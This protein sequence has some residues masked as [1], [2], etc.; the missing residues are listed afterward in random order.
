VYWGDDPYSPSAQRYDVDVVRPRVFDPILVAF[1]LAWSVV[2]GGVI[3]A[4][5]WAVS[6]VP[7]WPVFGGVTALLIVW[8]VTNS[9][10]KIRRFL[11]S[12][13][14]G[15]GG[16]WPDARGTRKPRRPVGGPSSTSSTA[17]DPNESTGP[18][19]VL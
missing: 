6:G 12:H 8:C 19:S 9:A 14:H 7:F 2:V 4:V 3:A 5:V 18:S 15:R 11:R 17:A 10:R 13:P 16:S 1:I